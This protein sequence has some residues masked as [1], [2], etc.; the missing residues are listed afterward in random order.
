MGKAEEYV[1]HG[2]TIKC[3]MGNKNATLKV[4]SNRKYTRKGKKVATIMDFAPGINLFP[5]PATFGICKPYSAIPPPGNLCTPIPIGPWKMPYMPKT[6]G[7]LHPLLG[8][9]CLTCG[10]GGGIITITKTG[11]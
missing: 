10:R 9:S 3:T 5:I 1:V 7:M 11:Q 6:I 4:S 8:K 2:A